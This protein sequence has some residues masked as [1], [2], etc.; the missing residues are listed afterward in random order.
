MSEADRE[1]DDSGSS[2]DTSVEMDISM[3][4]ASYEW[5][6]G[7]GELWHHL[8]ELRAIVESMRGEIESL[9]NENALL[10]RRIDSLITNWTEYR[11]DIDT[12]ESEAH[13]A[14]GDCY[15]NFVE[16]SLYG[17][18]RKAIAIKGESVEAVGIADLVRKICEE[19]FGRAE[20]SEHRIRRMLR[21]RASDELARTVHRVVVQGSGI[22]AQS[23]RMQ[24]RGF[25]E[26]DH[27]PGGSVDSARQRVWRKCDISSPV[28]FVVAPAYSANR[29]TYCR[30][31]VYTLST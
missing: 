28:Q 31:W 9:R 23:T 25:W 6:G 21:V 24:H 18:A 12:A 14:L 4:E 3:Q 17:L 1:W 30:Q 27:I 15:T 10:E 29:T 5:V 13:R 20:V 8:G 22:V 11:A 7:S 26:F 19:I 16:Q 2:G